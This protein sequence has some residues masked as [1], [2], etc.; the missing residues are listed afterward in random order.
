MGPTTARILRLVPFVAMFL[1][2]SPASASTSTVD[3]DS[4]LDAT[5]RCV[6]TIVSISPC[7]PHVAAVA[8][9]LAGSPPAP[10]DACCVAF[11]RAVSPSAAGGGEEGCLCHLLRNPLLLGFPIDAARLAALLPACAAGN[12]FAAATVEAATLFADACRELKALPQ[13]HFMP[14]STT[15]QE[16]SPAA[17]PELMSSPMEAVPPAGSMVRSGAEV[18]SSRGIPIAALILA[19]AGAV[20]T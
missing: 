3:A 17:V 13:L 14:Q 2:A 12:A 4:A 9:P 1:L 19:A 18:S 7:L 10:T 5:T 20:I 16:I 11:L 6:A 8:P 15:R